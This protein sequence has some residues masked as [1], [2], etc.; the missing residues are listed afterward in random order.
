MSIY[1]KYSG[2]MKITTR[3]NHMSHCKTASGKNRPNDWTY[4]VCIVNTHRDGLGL[5]I[6]GSTLECSCVAVAPRFNGSSSQGFLAHKKHRPLGP[7]SRAMLRPYGGPRGG[8][9]FL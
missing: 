3:L 7:Y 1:D 8:G 4:R 2:S 9:C 6:N 5:L